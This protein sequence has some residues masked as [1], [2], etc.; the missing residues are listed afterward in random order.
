[1]STLASRRSSRRRAARRPDR[2][3]RRQLDLHLAI[4]RLHPD[5]DRDQHQ[6]QWER[7]IE[8]QQIQIELMNENAP[9]RRGGG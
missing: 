5:L 2:R 4:R 6:H 3:L 8:I 7:L 9:G 1:M